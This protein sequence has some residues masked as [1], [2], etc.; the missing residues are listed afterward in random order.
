VTKLKLQPLA[1]WAW[2][3]FILI[4]SQAVLGAATVWSNKAADIATLHVV[5]GATSL[6]MGALLTFWAFQKARDRE[7]SALVTAEIRARSEPEHAIA[8]ATGAA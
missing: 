6:A 7:E 3:W 8:K 1:K 5:T 2:A 4:L